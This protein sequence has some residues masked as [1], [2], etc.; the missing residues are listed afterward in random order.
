MELQS[1]P[2]VWETHVVKKKTSSPHR[3]ASRY[4]GADTSWHVGLLWETFDTFQVTSCF[5]YA[6]RAVWKQRLNCSHNLKLSACG[7]TFIWWHGKEIGKTISSILKKKQNTSSSDTTAK[8][9][10]LWPVPHSVSI[11]LLLSFSLSISLWKWASGQMC[12]V[13]GIP[14]MLSI[15]SPVV[16]TH[17]HT[18]RVWGWCNVM[19]S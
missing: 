18:K 15:C 10:K 9:F 1:V 3:A 4:T 6:R 13:A 17:T 8:L 5:C 11:S 12:E 2:A 7:Q 16:Y 19:V 14:S